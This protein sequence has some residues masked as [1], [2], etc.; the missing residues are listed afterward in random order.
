MVEEPMCERTRNGC[1]NT[2]STPEPGAKNVLQRL[3]DRCLEERIDEGNDSDS[4]SEPLRVM[5]HGVPGAGKSEL[6]RWIRNFFE[7]V[8]KWTHGKEFVFLAS[9]RSMAA[10]IDGFT[11][12]SF[13]NVPF[14][15]SDGT[16][17][18]TKSQRSEQHGMSNLFLRYERLR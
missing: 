2:S 3:I 6:L 10:L 18:N 1:S 9:Q 12:H 7:T 4:R 15:K 11:F 8:C 5:L 17:V 13:C 16:I 14:M